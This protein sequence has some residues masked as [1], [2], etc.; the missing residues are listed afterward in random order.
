M[1]E[2]ASRRYSQGI[3]EALVGQLDQAKSLPY[4][5]IFN[6]RYFNPKKVDE[7]KRISASETK[8]YWDGDSNRDRVDWTR[9]GK[10]R[11]LPFMN[12]VM[13]EMSNGL[14]S[15]LFRKT[16][17]D[18][19]EDTTMEELKVLVGHKTTGTMTWVSGTK[20][21]KLKE[22]FGGFWYT[23]EEF[24]RFFDCY[25]KDVF[26][27]EEGAVEVTIGPICSSVHFGLI[28]NPHNEIYDLAVG[29]Y[30]LSVKVNK[31]KVVVFDSSRGFL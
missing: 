20:N 22:Y 9:L 24:N 29:E 12:Y 21:D 26:G 27:F 31:S 11:C 28:Q 2:S 16:R 13:G 23:R 18:I 8:L 10:E 15:Q 4:T 3:E 25:S 1:N 6:F 14:K 7:S 30:Y 19:T 17:F 5:D